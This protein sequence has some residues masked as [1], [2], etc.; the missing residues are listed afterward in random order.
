MIEVLN[1]GNEKDRL[2]IRAIPQEERERMILLVP[3][4][5]YPSYFFVDCNDPGYLRDFRDLIGPYRAIHMLKVDKLYEQADLKDY[6][7]IVYTETPT[8]MLD[9]IEH[10]DDPYPYDLNVE[11]K[12]FQRRAFNL[13]K[14]KKRTVLNWS[15]GTGKSVEGIALAKYYLEN[16]IDKVIVA[17]KG[18]NKSGWQ[19]QFLDIANLEAVIAEAPGSNAEIKRQR[20]LDIYREAPIF[21]IN[22]EKFRFKFKWDADNKEWIQNSKDGD[23]EELLSVLQG[24]KCFFIWD[25]MPSKMATMGSLHYKGVERLFSKKGVGPSLQVMLSATPIENQPE[26]TYSWVKILDKQSEPHF[27]S[28]SDFRKDY[29]KTFNPFM[30]WKV[31]SWDIE[32]LN[33]IPMIM[34]DII[35]KADKYK[36]PEIRREFPEEHWEDIIIDLSDEDRKIYE[37]IRDPTDLPE[38][39]DIPLDVL[40]KVSVLQ[41]ICNCS[42]WLEYSNSP[43]GKIAFERF[44]PKREQSNKLAELKELLNSLDCKVVLFSMYNDLGSKPLA[45][46]L[47]RWKIPFV[48]YTGKQ[49]QID[50]FENDPN[51]KVFVSSDMGKDGIN[52]PAGQAAINFDLPWT[53][54]TLTQRVNRISRINSKERH[55]LTADD[56][57]HL[58]FFNLLTNGTMEGRKQKIIKLKRLYHDT[59]FEGDLADAA[60]ILASAPMSDLLYLL[61]GDS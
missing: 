25:E 19:R 10:M 50:L 30:K 47:T 23:G 56:D 42:A 1:W 41:I 18:N 35:H 9:L 24:K 11:L 45:M 14:D 43:L 31:L 13:F 16:G 60:D 51:I 26:D 46:E 2:A 40:A 5:N 3:H 33:E 12:K 21:I 54:A 55:G 17:S 34:S 8:T 6:K 29:A 27:R 49:E 22:Y 32:K 59:V 7:Y 48:L 28:V 44:K 15:T 57:L 61:N 38:D 36:D 37:W 58:F 52:L 4:F 39:E 20:R 53:D